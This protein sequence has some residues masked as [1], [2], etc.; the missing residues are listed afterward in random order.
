MIC[1][2]SSSKIVCTRYFD[3]DEIQTAIFEHNGKLSIL[4]K[5]ANHPAT[6]EDLKI[7]AKATHIGVEVIMDGRIMGENLSRMGRDANWLKKQFNSQGHKDEKEIFLGVYIPE[8]DK[9]T[10]YP[11]D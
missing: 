10:L 5:A 8:E 2:Q 9:M 7:T 11:N 1:T 3:L 4:P 6:P